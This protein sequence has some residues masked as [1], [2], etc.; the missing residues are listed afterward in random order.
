MSALSSASLVAMGCLLAA[1][2]TV[3]AQSLLDRPP[4]ISGDWVVRPGTVMFNF[5]HR[6][7]RSDAPERKVSNFPTFLLAAGLPGRT[8]LGLHYSTNS[9]LTPRYPNEWEFFARYAP[10]SQ[11]TGA[12]LDLAGQLGYNLSSEGIDGEISIGERIGPVR[13]LGAARVL[14]SPVDDG[15]TRVALAGGGTVRVH[16]YVAIAGDVASI[17]DRDEVRGEKVAWSAGVHLAIPN[18][19]HTLSLQVTN[20]NTATLQGASAGSSERRYGFEFVVPITLA[21]YFGRGASRPETAEGARPA[22]VQPP[23]A[24]ADTAAAPRAGATVNAGI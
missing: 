13:L 20:T 6:F 21:R 11:E 17:L 15:D 22:P 5:L 9:T 10:L 1:A 8:M 16:R 4:N 14:S 2:P 3:A 19:P 18:T 12:P 7:T 24:A 23:A